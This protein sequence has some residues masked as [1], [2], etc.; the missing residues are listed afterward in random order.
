MSTSSGTLIIR[1]ICAKLTHDTETFGRMDPY[2]V[3]TVGR[4][5]HRTVVAK[6]AGKFPNW[7]DQL[8]YM[9]TNEDTMKIEVWDKDTASSDDLIG[10]TTLALNTVI[11]KS[12]YEEWVPLTY[13]GRK[14]GEIR[15][16][17]V[18]R[19]SG[20]PPSVHGIPA[21]L[22]NMGGRQYAP[23]PAPYQYPPQTY[24]QAPPQSMYPTLSPMQPPPMPYYPPQAPYPQAYPQNPPS[25]LNPQQSPNYYYQQPPPQN[26]PNFYPYAPK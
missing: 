14:A 11:S 26:V 16:N 18:F 7:E 4:Q 19:P 12:N 20:P 2:C 17:I 21:N 9:K 13:K 5:K 6:S 8:S 24:P 22:V 10:E 25:Y 1:P 23:M 15:L 3:I